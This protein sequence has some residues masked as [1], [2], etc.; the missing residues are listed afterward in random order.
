MTDLP[1]W[2]TTGKDVLLG[3]AAIV[4]SSVAI[5]GLR[6][7]RTELRGKADFEIARGLARA[8][9]KLR[10]ELESYRAPFV[11]GGEFPDS[12]YQ[13]RTK[14]AQDE[15]QGWA[16]VYANRWR[17]VAAAVE[18]FDSHTLEAE[19]LWGSMA[20]KKAE[21]LRECIGSLNAATEAVLSD[22]AQGGADFRADPE[23]GKRMRSDLSSS[24]SDTNNKLTAS[25]T[26]A[27]GDIEEMLR[28]HLARK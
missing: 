3:L 11:R 8:T 24:R 6:R 25:I 26:V 12:Y 21:A 27:V 1:T 2:I 5:I 14:T 28:P 22:K 17:F 13:A 20:R 15:A 18:E 23:F 9:Y 19:A 4:T 7:W 10:N 16:H